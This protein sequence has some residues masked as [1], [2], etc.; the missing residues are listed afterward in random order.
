MNTKKNEMFKLAILDEPQLE[1]RYNQRMQDPHDGLSLLGPFDFDSP[2]HPESITYAVIGTPKGIELFERWSYLMS[3]PSITAEED[4]PI[5]WPSFPGFDAAFGS[6][7]QNLTAWSYP[8][9]RTNLLENTRSNDPYK[10]AYQVV[11]KYLN[12]LRIGRKRDEVFDIFICI[13]PDEVYTNCRIKSRVPDGIG[14]KISKRELDLKTRGQI[15]IFDSFEVDQYRLSNDFRRQ[16]KARAM[17]YGVPIQIIRESTLTTIKNKSQIRQITSMSDRMW[18]LSTALYYKAG[19]KPWRL[20][21]A[22]DG[23]CYIGLAFRIATKAIYGKTAVCAAQMFLDSGDGIVFLGEYGPWYSPE[24]KQ[25]HL[26]ENAAYN[27]LSG[28]LN[29]YQELEGKELK[30]IFL[31]S[32]STINDEEFRAYRHACPSGV[33]LVGIRVRTEKDGVRLFRNSTHPVIRGTFLCLR[34]KSGYLWASDYKP[35]LETY[36][37]WEVLKPLRIDIQH[38]NADIVQ[39]AR[40]IFGLTKL[41]YNSC[42]LGDSEPVTIGYSDA[43]GEILVSNPTIK[44]SNPNFKFYI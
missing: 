25:F 23:V 29:T 26:D 12:G 19:G 28:V 33:K 43:A 13:V 40:D 36:D 39:V 7:W 14:P 30:E 42:K 38:G 35:R 11:N 2:S 37:G 20:S 10:R 21:T 32:R 16:I 41:N 24:N 9:E 8:I 34:S 15:D 6:K 18:N 17:S 22:R 1:F 27:L 31:H 44:E 5:L 4:N 3:K